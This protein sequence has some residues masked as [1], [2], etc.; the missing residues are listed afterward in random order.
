MLKE[1][2][3]STTSPIVHWNRLFTTLFLKHVSTANPQIPFSTCFLNNALIA[4][5]IRN[6]I[7]TKGSVNPNPITPISPNLPIGTSMAVVS[8]K[9][10]KTSLRVLIKNPTSMESFVFHVISL[11]TGVSLQIFA[12]N[13]KV[14]FHSIRT[15]ETAKKLSSM[16]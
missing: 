10:T 2:S 4:N 3:F 11:T 8:P 16:N 9:S 7:L 1:P 6:L 14:D 13:A 15:L 5:Q 12:R